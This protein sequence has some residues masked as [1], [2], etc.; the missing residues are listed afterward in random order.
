MA[1]LLYR[2]DI[3]QVRA[4]L[5]KWWNGGDIGR[6]AMQV[7]V[8]LAVPREGIPEMPKPDG[9]TAPWYTVKS[10]DYRVNWMQRQHLSVCYMGDAVPQSSPDLAP[11]CLALYLG[12]KGEEGD[13]TVWCEPFIHDLE[14]DDFV[15]DENNFYWQ[16]TL[17]LLREIVRLG[18]GK[19][20]AHFPDLIEGL[21]T[22]AGMRDSQSLLM[23]MID[24]PDWV[25]RQLDRITDLYFKYY[26]VLYEMGKDE[27]GGSI[28]WA[29]GPGRTAKLQ[30]D[31]S[32]MIGP[33]MYGEFMVPVLQ[34]M[35]DRL[36]CVIYHW[37]GPGA[38]PHHDHILGLGNLK[39]LQWTP[40][41][42]TDPEYDRRWWP[43]YHK[44]IEHGKRVL[45]GVSGS[46]DEVTQRLLAMKR[47]FGPKFKSF[48]F[49]T[50]MP[51][52]KAAK[53]LLATISD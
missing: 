10:F 28:F 19:F 4:R 24:S 12:C 17:R 13:G 45:I 31:F 38:I 21:D 43:L 50:W 47:D 48:M 18:K 15:S 53:N 34:K 42:G 52:E 11:N 27:T 29:W 14:R 35:C 7:F 30:C 39:V 1:G 46:E 3:D 40:G 26:D 25:H 8:P 36:D 49:N 23:D 37:D 41:S 5:T 9:V 32:A 33:E 2:E 20:L 16:F 6:P 51:S 44:T 22:L